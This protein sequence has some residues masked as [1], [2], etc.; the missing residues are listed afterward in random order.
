MTL[1]SLIAL[2]ILAGSPTAVPLASPA[3]QPPVTPVVV[4]RPFAAPA[5]PYSPGH[6]GVD[7]AAPPG[8][9]VRASGAGVVRFAGTV[10]GKGVVSIE[11]PHRILGRSGWRTTYEDVSPQV[12]AGQRVRA[13]QRIGTLAA[14]GHAGGLHWGLRHGRAYADPLLLLRR[15]IALKPLR[16]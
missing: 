12:K 2:T 7:L 11:H 15:P 13:G 4:E 6:R 16:R 1:T 9:A 3:W 8:A 10:A 5:G 14:H